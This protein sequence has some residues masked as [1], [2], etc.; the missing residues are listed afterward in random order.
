MLADQRTVGRLLDIHKA[1]NEDSASRAPPV[2]TERRPI[3][4]KA[5]HAIPDGDWPGGGFADTTRIDPQ[6]GASPGC[7]LQAHDLPETM[8]PKDRC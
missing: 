5:T 7:H 1:T 4:R 2:Y 8:S 3:S 6:D